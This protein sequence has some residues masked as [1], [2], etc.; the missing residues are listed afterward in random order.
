MTALTN[1]EK[2]RVRYHLGYLGVSP[3]SSISLGIPRLQDTSF[4]IEMSMD[5]VLPDH[6]SKIRQI[7]SYMDEIEKKEFDALNRLKASSLGSLILRPDEIEALG[8]AYV[9]WGKRL[10]DI[11]GVEPYRFSNRYSSTAHIACIPVR[12]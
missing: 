2:A 9:S 7:I 11:L 12:H 6:L 8:K 5:H 1:E 4:L 3:S 10:G